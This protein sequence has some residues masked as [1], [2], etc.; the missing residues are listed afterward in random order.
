LAVSDS[1]YESLRLA[2]NTSSEPIRGVISIACIALAV[3]QWTIYRRRQ[4]FSLPG[5]V[6]LTLTMVSLWLGLNVIRDYTYPRHSME[7]LQWYGLV[8]RTQELLIWPILGG[9]L[10]VT[11]WTTLRLAHWLAARVS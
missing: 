5:F 8:V 2:A 11:I 1:G 10:V 6:L 7:I 9:V 3:Y 4:R